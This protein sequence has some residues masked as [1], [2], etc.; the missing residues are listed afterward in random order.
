M[1]IT[2]FIFSVILISGAVLCC[3]AHDVY[4][5]EVLP[6]NISAIVLL[7]F[8][9]GISGFLSQG[10]YF[11]IFASAAALIAGIFISVKKKS[12]RGMLKRLFTPAFYIFIFLIFSLVFF[13][14]G[15]LMHCWDDF[16][17]WGDVVKVM[18]TIDVMST[19]PQSMSLYPE[20][21]PAMALLQYLFQKL[22]LI[23]VPGAEFT[24]WPLFFVYQLFMF[25][26]AFPLLRIFDFKKFRTYILLFVL[27]VSP[28]AFFPQAFF[29]LK[30]DTFLGALFAFA[31]SYLLISPE[32]QPVLNFCIFGISALM[33]LTKSS[34]IMFALFTAVAF[35]IFLHGSKNTSRKRRVSLSAAEFSF[36]LVPYLLWEAS[37]RIN[38]AKRA[39][40]LSS[41]PR[42]ADYQMQSLSEFIKAFFTKSLSSPEAILE[43]L[44]PAFLFIVIFVL[45]YL[46]KDLLV[47]AVPQRRSFYN[48]L[49][50]IV[51]A[52]FIVF[53]AGLCLSYLTVFSPEEALEMA[54]F[55]RYISTVYFSGILIL[56]FSAAELIHLRALDPIK[57]T[58]AVLCLSA[59]ITPWLSFMYLITRNNVAF[60]IKEREK[61]DIAA[62][63]IMALDDWKDSRFYIVAADIFYDICLRYSLRPADI[64]PPD[65]WLN[66]ASN[67]AADNSLCKSEAWKEMLKNQYDYVYISV[68]GDYFAENYAENFKDPGDIKNYSLYKVDKSTGILSFISQSPPF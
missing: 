67:E 13:N 26:M 49:Y 12:F 25:S 64:N 17:H 11:I 50:G 28:L 32:P 59:A 7:L 10:V 55:E 43:K 68:P 63:Q 51:L 5:E 4:F 44:T 24:E 54:G 66:E 3:S 60:S 47:K 53:T 15:R 33:V 62:E 35:I 21:P 41:L 8:L 58:A 42:R 16:S 27:F 20:Y 39:F 34:G 9:F 46:E 48:S 61:Y 6:V 18:T 29:I 40:D 56:I 30:I 2:V 57:T 38:A 23:L 19:S 31:I 45:L 14:K 37:V 52:A 22:H 36:I 65:T 1:L